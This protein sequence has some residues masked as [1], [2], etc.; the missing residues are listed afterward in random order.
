M[1]DE[2]SP[3]PDERLSVGN[4]AETEHGGLAGLGHF[5]HTVVT[6]TP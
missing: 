2:R 5:L 1:G 6:V 4:I 3:L